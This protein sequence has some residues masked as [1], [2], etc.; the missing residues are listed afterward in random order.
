MGELPPGALGLWTTG[1]Q[2]P[3]RHQGLG[4]LHSSAAPDRTEGHGCEHSSRKCKQTTLMYFII[5]KTTLCILGYI[6]EISEV[7]FCVLRKLE[8]MCTLMC[9]VGVN[10]NF[11]AYI[12]S[13]VNF[14]LGSRFTFYVQLY[15]LLATF[16]LLQE[17]DLHQR[18]ERMLQEADKIDCRSFV[19]AHDVVSGN[20]RLNLAFM[21][22]LFNSYPALEK[23]EDF[24]MEDLH[25][26]TGEEKSKSK[27]KVSN[28]AGVSHFSGLSSNMYM[29]MCVWGD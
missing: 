29:C 8:Q 10:F 21:A 13:I 2:L 4:H 16:L 24:D 19:S 25:E 7:I 1:R 5:F 26:A 3:G 15:M 6:P 17:A 11:N 27:G 28:F 14:L 12:L 22:N 20:Y 23:P 9:V 18:A